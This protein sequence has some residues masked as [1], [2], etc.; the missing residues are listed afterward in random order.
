MPAPGAAAVQA[1]N[2][3]GI[4]VI[5]SNTRVNSDLLTAYVGSN[6]V[7]LDRAGLGA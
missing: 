4:P 5:G 3:A 7:D 6:D 2:N 1:A